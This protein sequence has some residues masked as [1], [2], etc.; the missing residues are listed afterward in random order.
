MN[1][2]TKQNFKDISSVK[3]FLQSHLNKI[4]ESY[5]SISSTQKEFYFKN[6]ESLQIFLIHKIFLNWKIFMTEKDI[7]NL[8]HPYFINIFPLKSIISLS[9]S[10]EEQTLEIQNEIIMLLENLIKNDD[11]LNHLLNEIQV[12]SIEIDILIKVILTLS[13]KIL[14]QIPSS[15]F[16]SFKNYF[17]YIVKLII[18]NKT[19]DEK[20]ISKF[21]S[22]I[23]QRGHSDVCCQ[24]IL[25]NFEFKNQ[26]EWM[27]I[28]LNLSKL[29][30]ETFS[31]NLLKNLLKNGTFK[32]SIQIIISNLIK[33]N[34]SWKNLYLNK[35]LIISTFE[36]EEMKIILKIIEFNLMEEEEK[37][38]FDLLLKISKFW[39]E[40]L[41]IKNSS[42]KQH[43]CKYDKTK[44]LDVTYILIFLLNFIEK[45][46]L[47]HSEILTCL[48]E[49]IHNRL[50]NTLPYI[51]R[52]ASI[53]AEKFT[54]IVDPKNILTFDNFNGELDKIEN[55]L[56]SIDSKEQE[57]L[58]SKD[59]ILNQKDEIKANKKI[60]KKLMLSNDPDEL[61][62]HS[63]EES[64]IDSDTDSLQSFDLEEDEI[65]DSEIKPP[66][67]VKE[68]L[69]YL[70][71]SKDDKFE[72]EKLEMALKFGEEVIR[73]APDDLKDF[74]IQISKRLLYNLESYSIENFD[75]MK[76]KLQVALIVN[77]TK[78]LSKFLPD[79]FYKDN[80]NISQRVEILNALS[81]AALELSN[82]LKILID[83]LKRDEENKKEIPMEKKMI[84]TEY[85]YPEKTRIWSKQRIE[86][87]SKIN[88]FS[89]F[90]E[91]FFY[92]LLMKKKILSLL[93]QDS[94]LLSSLIDCLGI[95][96]YCSGNDLLSQKL[97]KEFLNFIW[98]IKFSTYQEIQ[99]QFKN[100]KSDEIKSVLSIRRSILK[101]ILRSFIMLNEKTIIE[102]FSEI[103]DSLFT[104]LFDIIQNDPDEICKNI[105]SSILTTIQK[106][107]KNQ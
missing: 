28:F 11:F 4:P 65:E 40:S 67:Y 52:C 20:I 34:S 37:F 17:S 107:L 85:K 53:I 91:S 95:F 99:I 51:R 7:I 44:L 98:S 21:I 32:K 50:S 55:L 88:R 84:E 49:G 48:I 94:I 92:P 103:V 56:F 59:D 70:S 80:Y 41:F 25:N 15:E 81:D 74:S 13:D 105:S 36:I 63:D 106:K 73:F 6:L 22:S 58:L 35:F 76:H 87:G 75:L 90:C 18:R 2:F 71:S 14:N 66:K 33:E 38:K 60:K 72:V 86:N 19:M 93:N 64:D 5:S 83:F 62:F 26:K 3:Q 16:F 61:I 97:G 9:Q 104:W 54:K 30:I 78:E 102:E 101:A 100:E 82:V 8:I 96:V 10:L 39:K 31:K 57:N 12:F 89:P 69:E 23:V 29:S 77:S 45:S 79:E 24:E 47:E 68:L 46:K 1:Y 43:E 42:Q 27:I